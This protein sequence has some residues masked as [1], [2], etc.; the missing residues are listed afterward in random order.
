MQP[1]KL[2][3]R[4]DR[5]VVTVLLALSLPVIVLLGALVF[6]LARQRPYKREA[7]GRAD[8]AAV[9][10]AVGC[11][12]G[13]CAPAAASAAYAGNG[14]TVQSAACSSG[15]CTVTMHKPNDYQ[16]VAGSN[17]VPAS[18][19][20]KWGAL[21]AS[22][23]VFPLT[24]S[25]CAFAIQFNVPVTLHS[26]AFGGCN[27]PAGQFGFVAG[28]CT[29]QT[30][31]FGEPL[32]GTTGNNLNGTGCTDMNAFL[33]HEWLV[34][35]WTTASGQGAGATYTVLSF[36]KFYVTGWSTNGNQN[37]GGTLAAMC[38]ATANGDPV[39]PAP[40]DAN[41]PCIRG[42]FKGFTTQNGTI[43]PG[44]ACKDNLLACRVYLDH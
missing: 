44:L 35:V 31:V 10:A 25:T 29:N 12:K 39:L 21:G 1:G 38:D 41:K 34:P 14:V 11:S 9:A 22:T 17:N 24:I 3:K 15:S 37:H 13:S 8:A 42:Y 30:V 7:Q 43:V 5:G 16:F 28:G 33:N 2:T 20:A 27:N 40:S 23:G 32:H 26:Y 18:A 19:T 36:A 6:D 4:D